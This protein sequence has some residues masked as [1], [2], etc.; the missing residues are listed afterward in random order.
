MSMQGNRIALIDVGSNSVHMCI[1]QV[2][3]ESFEKV[4]DVR[5]YVRLGLHI[6]QNGVMS[7]EGMAAGGA[8]IKEMVRLALEEGSDQVHVFATA[9]VRNC[10][11]SAEAVAAME[12]IAG[13]NVRVLSGEEEARLSAAGA[14]R[15]AETSSG[16]FFDLGGG[17]TEI[18]CLRNGRLT[19]WDSLPVGAL[20]IWDNPSNSAFPSAME[21]EAI[22][23]RVTTMLQ[24]SR[25]E[26]ANSAS[27]CGVG[28]TVR[29]ALSVAN[30]MNDAPQSNRTLS[31]S[32]LEVIVAMAEDAP[33]K[34]AEIVLSLKSELVRAFVPGCAIMRVI[35]KQAGCEA[36]EVAGTSVREGFLVE[37]VLAN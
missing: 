2:D 34:L 31:L 15:S 20:S 27:V 18:A 32:D 8:S 17:S 7:D 12:Q 33:D 21:I 14:L 6:D 25:V 9:A 26:V 1:Y 3:G 29:L 24:A 35:L 30:L 19:E 16:V 36:I 4:D 5:D 10:S 23:Q 22:G 28:G 37:E 11:N 13:C